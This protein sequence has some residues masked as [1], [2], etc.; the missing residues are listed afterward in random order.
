MCERVWCGQFQMHQI[1]GSGSVE[2]MYCVNDVNKEFDRNSSHL[3]SLPQC[4]VRSTVPFVSFFS[5]N[6]WLSCLE[7]EWGRKVEI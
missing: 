3:N 4:F 6:R 5:E 2:N 7:E 1:A